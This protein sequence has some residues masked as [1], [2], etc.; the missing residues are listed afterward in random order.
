MNSSITELVSD[1][2]HSIFLQDLVVGKHTPQ[3]CSGTEIKCSLGNQVS[4]N[5][6]RKM[7]VRCSN[8]GK[9]GIYLGQSTVSFQLKLPRESKGTS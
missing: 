2:D 4:P 3:T 1:K 9:H 5:K 7:I 6:A 8:T